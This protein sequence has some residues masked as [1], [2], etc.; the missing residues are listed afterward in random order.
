MSKATAALSIS[1]Q[2]ADF[3]YR[4][5]LNKIPN[6][7]QQYAMHLILDGT[8]I[9]YASSQY[10]FSKTGLEA[11]RLFNEQGDHTVLGTGE[12]MAFR[13]AALANGLLIHGLDFD[14]THVAGVVHLTSAVWPCVLA[15]A[16]KNAC[17]GDE[18]L[19]A[20]IAGMEVGA[21]LGMVAK[22]AF[23]QVG[24][25]PT[26]LVGTF[27]CSLAACK[28]MKLSSEEMVMAQGI[29][30][31][32]ASGNFEFVEDGA[33]TKRYHPGWA[34]VSGIMS[35]TFA[36]AGYVGPNLTYE[37][38]FGLF[39]SHL[40][41]LEHSCDYALATDG[42][43]T[44]W[45][46]MNVG[47]KPY[48]SCHFT[49]AVIDATRKLSIEHDLKADQIERIVTLVPD[50][51]IKTVCEPFIKKQSPQC[52][53]DA[54]FSAPYLVAVALV[55]RD[56]SLKDLE[57]EPLLDP[58]VAELT[59]KVFYE[60]DPDSGFPTYYSGEVRITLKNGR[61]L[62]QRE[63]KN[64][65]CF[66][67]PLSVDDILGKFFDNCSFATTRKKAEQVKEAILGMKSC[68]HVTELTKHL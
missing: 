64:H 11:L 52:A 22:G 66:D 61:T 43:N 8:G 6:D 31:S 1:Q 63:F 35:A 36:K 10:S 23:H 27:A 32:M 15:V 38:R 16:E 55:R 41:G 68:Q 56:F 40:I 33:W 5:E 48:P 65:G 3:V 18:M 67:N 14:D 62:S 12:K 47:V 9:A 60:A 13:D 17:S 29:A 57:P 4:L 7:V 25:H 46:T 59:K 53:Y 34:A 30:L 49:H 26:G 51:V 37:G 24:H 28:L 58:V 21:R 19:N 42:L 39:K 2:L 54:Q 20:Y 45:E 44:V 50:E